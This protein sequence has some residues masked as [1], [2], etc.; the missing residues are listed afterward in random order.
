MMQRARMVEGVC[1]RAAI[2]VAVCTFPLWGAQTAHLT[3]R[4]VDE[5]VVPVNS[6]RVI[7]AQQGRTVVETFTDD[8]GHFEFD[9][10]MPGEATVSVRKPEYFELTG[11]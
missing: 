5:N 7:L 10:L 1:R 3:G 6:A 4:V 11:A 2:L 9:V 8:S